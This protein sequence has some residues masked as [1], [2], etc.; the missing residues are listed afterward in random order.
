MA[1]APPNPP[2]IPA[3]DENV[4]GSQPD[5][6]LIVMHATVSSDNAGKARDIA[7][8]WQTTVTGSS[9]HYIRDARECI[10]AVGDHTVAYHCGY[11]FRSVGYEMCDEQ[12][13]PVTRWSDADS[14]A[15]IRGSARDVARLGL[16]YGIPLRRLSNTQLK[17]WADAGK[18]ARLGGIVSHEQMSEV[19]K[20]STH[21]DP[22]DFP[23][24]KFMSLVQVEKKALLA[25][26]SIIKPTDPRYLHTILWNAK[27]TMKESYAREQLFGMLDRHRPMTAMLQEIDWTVGNTNYVGFRGDDEDAD[28]TT[29][30]L[31]RKDLKILD[32]GVHHMEE[33]YIGPHGHPRAPRQFPWARLQVG[34]ETVRVASIHMPAVKK[35]HPAWVEADEY[36]TKAMK[37][38]N[39][40][41]YGGDWNATGTSL[42]GTQYG[43]TIDH[44]RLVNA[45]GVKKEN[46]GF[47]GSDHQAKRMVAKI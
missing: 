9:A 13:G 27:V 39:A 10:Q 29:V 7:R 16:A 24:T 21:T 26:D 8:W 40:I 15:I 5:P 32:H 42:P 6:T 37:G 18:P 33:S 23:W 17:A 19:F 30:L 4:G 45:T 11:N 46:L 34:P 47:H 1:I 22:R 35:T 2:F 44:L 14:T 36:L 25:G 12:V 3:R 28:Q 31:V 43:E 38:T 20:K 41:A